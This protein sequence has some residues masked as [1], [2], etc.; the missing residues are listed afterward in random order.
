MAIG[1]TD[2]ALRSQLLDPAAFD[3]A[4]RALPLPE[5]LVARLVPYGPV[6]RMGGLVNRIRRFVDPDGWPLM[7]GFHAIGD[8]HT[9]TN[10]IYGRGCSLALVQAVALT[11]ALTAE[12]ADPPD[13]VARARAYEGACRELTEPWYHISVETD[14][15]RQA[16]Y[17]RDGQPGSTDTPSVMDQLLRL[18]A[19]DPIVGRAILRA[20]NLLATP[21]QLMNEADVM[22]RIVEL[23]ATQS[24]APHPRNRWAREGP[25]RQEMIDLTAA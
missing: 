16:R 3:R 13:P 24:P 25:S 5:G 2:A 9:C 8:A 1:A 18:G 4:A 21:Q 12:Q 20:V 7:L 19:D 23:A 11:D 17:Q 22:T 14:R 15:A 10:P 6:H